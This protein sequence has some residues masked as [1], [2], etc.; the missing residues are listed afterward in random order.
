MKTLSRL[1]SRDVLLACSLLLAGCPGPAAGT[2]PEATVAA[3]ASALREGDA[4]SAYAMMSESYR[5]RVSLEELRTML[6]E[7]AAEAQA[8][9]RALGQR[10]GPAQVEAVVEYGEG[11]RLRLAREGDQWRVLTDIVDYYDQST[12]RAA[13]RSFVR[14]MERRRYDVVLRL[15]PAADREGMSVE[16][17][18]ASWEGEG[19]EEAERLVAGLRAAL[20]NAI[21][22]V[23]DRATMPY[24]E[25]FQVHFVREDGVW[26]IEDP[27]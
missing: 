24:G 16:Q 11:E 13:L 5:R 9:A 18:R 12:P 25:R 27:D 15:I 17:M 26:R 7:N 4:Q 8:T 21:E 3:F 14:A 19:R 2:T 23:G 20:E 10:A 6:R 1:R 22:E